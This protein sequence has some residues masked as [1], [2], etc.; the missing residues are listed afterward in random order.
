MHFSFIRNIAKD[1][2]E[3]C[4]IELIS[5]SIII[6]KGKGVG[7]KTKNNIDVITINRRHRMFS[8][9]KIYTEYT[10]SN[11]IGLPLINVLLLSLIFL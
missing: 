9:T 2:W 1:V 6:G 4:V 8:D 5:F 10:Y 7:Y 3:E 11:H